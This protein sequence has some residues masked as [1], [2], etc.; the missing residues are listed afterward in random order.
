MPMPGPAPRPR[1]SASAS[2]ARMAL[3][4]SSALLGGFAVQQDGEFVAAGARAAGRLRRRLLQDLGDA[5]EQLVAGEVAVE[6]VDPLEMVEVEQEQDARAA[7]RRAR[8]GSSAAVPGGW[9][10]RW[11]GRCWRCAGPAARPSRRRRAPACRSFDRRQPNRMIAILSRNAMVRL[12]LG[13]RDAAESGAEHLA[14]Q[15]DEQQEGRNRRA[16]GDQMA[17][18]DPDGIVL[19]ASRPHDVAGSPLR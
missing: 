18:G 13:R 19:H 4:T 16:A 5:L 2:R 15:P 6:V 1:R 3:A 7:W 12:V 9:Q 10:G 17:A 14:A 8:R 11:R